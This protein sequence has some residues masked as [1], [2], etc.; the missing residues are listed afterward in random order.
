MW[1]AL[2]LTLIAVSSPASQAQPEAADVTTI[3]ASYVCEH[4]VHIE[5]AYLNFREGTSYAALSYAG[6]LVLMR[7]LPAASGTR[8]ADTDEQRGWRWY[9]RGADAFLSVMPADDA[10]TEAPI[11]QGCSAVIVGGA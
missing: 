4:G 1:P 10:A 11:V 3:E 7:Q 5:A 9:T 2:A 6:N 8:Y